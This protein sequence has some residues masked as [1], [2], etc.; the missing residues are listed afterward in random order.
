MGTFSFF[1]LGDLCA[2]QFVD[3]AW[4]RAKVEKVSGSSVSVKYVDYGNREV[5]QSLKCASLP[6]N[7]SSASPYAHEIHLAL[8]KFSKDVSTD[9]C[10]LK[11]QI[12]LNAITVLG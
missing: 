12:K 10:P 3:G 7:F 5:T 4:Y 1:P 8:V 2:A 9:Y 6:S 11:K